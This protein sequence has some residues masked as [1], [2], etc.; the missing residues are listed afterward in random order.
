MQR[1]PV[2]KNQKKEKRKKKSN[3]ASRRQRT[4]TEWHEYLKTQSPPPE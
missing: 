1:N 2:S 4:H 3:P